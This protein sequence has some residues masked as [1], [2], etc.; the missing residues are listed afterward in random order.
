MQPDSWR[1]QMYRLREREMIKI[2]TSAIEGEIEDIVIETLNEFGTCSYETTMRIA[3]YRTANLI[4]KKM[5]E[6][7]E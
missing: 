1:I 6:M 2:P 5:K 4:E 3:C 7:G